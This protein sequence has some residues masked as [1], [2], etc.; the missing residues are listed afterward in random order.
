[1]RDVARVAGVAV[2]TVYSN[3]GSKIG[4]VAR[5]HRRGGGRRHRADP[6][7]GT[8]GVRRAR[9]RA[10]VRPGSVPRRGWSVRFTSA[11]PGSAGRCG[12]RRRA[13]PS[14]RS[15]WQRRRSGAA[16]RRP[17]RASDRRRPISDTTRDGLWAV[18]GMEVYQLLVVRAGWSADALRGLV[19]E[20]RSAVCCGRWERRRD[21]RCTGCAGRHAD[22]GHRPRRAATRPRPCDRCALDGALPRGSAADR[23]RR[24]RRLDDGFPR[25]P[26]PRRGCRAVATG[27][28]PQSPGRATARRHG[29]RPWPRRSRWSRPARPPPTPTAAERPTRHESSCSKRW[30]VC[31]R[32]CSR[33]SNARS[34]R[35][36]HSSRSASPPR[37]G[38]PST[39]STSSSPSRCRSSASKATGCSMGSIPNAASSWSIRYRRSPDSC[40]CTASPV[41]IDGTR[42][43]AGVRPAARS[44]SRSTSYGPA[45]TLPRRIPR[46]GHVDIV[47]DAPIDAVWNVVTDV[48]RVGEWSH[49]C[50]RVEWL[51]GATDRVA[52]GA[53]SRHEQGG[54]LDVEPHQ[55]S[56]RRRRTAHVRVANRARPSGFPT[57]AS[58]GSSSSPS[59]RGTRITQSFQVIRAPAVLAALYA[60]IVPS[61]SRSHRRPHRRPPPPRRARR[62]EAGSPA[63]AAETAPG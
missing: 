50:R 59:T 2:E 6:A 60:I 38:T 63:A 28:Q 24:P 35:R 45:A 17:G 49:E 54:S 20:T 57:A 26:P 9:S 52:R 62:R 37:N 5:R 25:R 15:G 29:S 18:L 36:C 53:L 12:R 61:P 56:P 13:T 23:D 16:E 40:S 51:D 58:G 34:T 33:T 43:P 4:A 19:G 46:T 27:A 32:R 21:E 1:M 44:G 3:F 14:W 31:A 11:P 48:T 41:A 10:A 8:A 55:R 7:R 42:R 39:S 47:V 30:E 22:D